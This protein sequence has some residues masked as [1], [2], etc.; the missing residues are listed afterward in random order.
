MM[1]M[2][3]SRFWA[4]HYIHKSSFANTHISGSNKRIWSGGVFLVMDQ[5]INRHISVFYFPV[6][7]KSDEAHNLLLMYWWVFRIESNIFLLK[8]CF[9]LM[10]YIYTGAKKLDIHGV[11]NE[12]NWLL[13]ILWRSVFILLS[14]G[15]FSHWKQALWKNTVERLQEWK[16][17]S[18]VPL[19]DFLI[20]I[21]RYD[22]E[23]SLDYTRAKVKG[24]KGIKSYKKMLF[25]DNLENYFKKTG[26]RTN[27]ST[28]QLQWCW[29]LY[30]GGV[31]VIFIFGLYTYCLL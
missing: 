14:F 22:T 6:N 1:K 15:V 31:I 9:W 13:L 4:L 21:G 19:F 23:K 3:C 30:Q 11:M 28:C 20:M 26:W 16:K 25:N 12:L 24:D 5:E 7:K 10:W 8:F 17:S 27:W 2:T 29:Q 18:I